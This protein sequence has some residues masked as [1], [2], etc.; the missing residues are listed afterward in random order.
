MIFIVQW[1][2]TIWLLLALLVVHKRQWGWVLGFMAACM[3]M[4]R[5]Q[6][7]LMTST[8]HPYGFLPLMES[9]VFQRGQAAYSIFYGIYLILAYYS[10]SARPAI[11]MAA[12][13]SMFFTA[14]FVSM[15]VMVL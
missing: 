10:P 15:I 8:G 6:A 7:E 4:M 5:L 14:L 11:M 12:S 13:V 2:D 1:I 9:H 3:L